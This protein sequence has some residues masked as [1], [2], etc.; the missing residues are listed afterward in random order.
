MTDFSRIPTTHF[1]ANEPKEKSVLRYIGAFFRRLEEISDG[2]IVIIRYSTKDSAIPLTRPDQFPSKLSALTLGQAR[3][4]LSRLPAE[5]NKNNQ[6][7]CDIM[8]LTNKPNLVKEEARSLYYD[9][10]WAIRAT[11]HQIQDAERTVTAGW[12]PYTCDMLQSREIE[13][14]I[15]LKLK[16]PVMMKHK[17]I[18]AE[19]R[20]DSVVTLD[21]KSKFHKSVAATATEGK[22]QELPFADHFMCRPADKPQVTRFLQEHFKRGGSQYFGYR[23]MR[24]VPETDVMHSPAMRKFWQDAVDLQIGFKKAAAIL[25][26][27][28]IV[29]LERE[30]IT[31]EGKAISLQEVVETY[32]RDKDDM[33]L[34]IRCECLRSKPG[35]NRDGQHGFA[36]A[37]RNY[38]VAKNFLDNLLPYCRFK[39]GDK[40]NSWFT[41]AEQNL[42]QLEIWDPKIEGVTQ[43][44]Q[45]DDK[46]MYTME[47]DWEFLKGDSD[48]EVDVTA[49]TLENVPTGPSAGDRALGRSGAT[50]SLPSLR[51]M[52]ASGGKLPGRV[53]RTQLP[54]GSN[55]SNRR[56]RQQD[57]RSCGDSTR[58]R[59]DKLLLALAD[60][61]DSL[62]LDYDES[63]LQSTA[64]D[65]TPAILRRRIA[66]M[67]Q[68]RCDVTTEF[69]RI[70]KVAPKWIEAKSN[71]SRSG[72]SSSESS[73][74][75]TPQ[76]RG[77]DT[78]GSPSFQTER[79][80]VGDA[81]DPPATSTTVTPGTGTNGKDT[82]HHTD[83]GDEM[84]ECKDQNNSEPG[85]DIETNN[86]LDTDMIDCTMEQQS[87]IGPSGGKSSATVDNLEVNRKGGDGPNHV[88]QLSVVASSASGGKGL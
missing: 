62:G 15:L 44:L 9:G 43:S 35:E 34:F 79:S 2:K 53:N 68:M 50:D 86:D 10:G 28:G 39:F 60:Q 4:Y 20:N 30:I 14:K 73:G 37:P 74:D 64:S 23:K 82:D 46:D 29:D 33:P 6:M 17:R 11:P 19:K 57:D 78:T 52:E 22:T 85:H 63:S 8:I 49:T 40:A 84:R 54:G 61:C 67:D 41:I 32:Q 18:Q 87:D 38:A 3:K 77:G 72:Q 55:L 24:F 31:N 76:T 66:I 21:Y 16:V 65:Q 45:G 1:Y 58:A 5:P 42:R 70:G 36:I 51:E 26:K 47:A 80:N 12:G 71:A 27:E 69:K 25:V 59:V 7:W 56:R 88:Q 13:R 83:L 81:L 48:E 75:V